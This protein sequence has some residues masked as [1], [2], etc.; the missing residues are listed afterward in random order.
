MLIS[1]ED[2]RVMS[3]KLKTGNEV[4]TMMQTWEN[5]MSFSYIKKPQL[6][7]T[8]LFQKRHKKDLK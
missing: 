1:S 7:S 8:T 4:E 2:D 5:A 6:L 3:L